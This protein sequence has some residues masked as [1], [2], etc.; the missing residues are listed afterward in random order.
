[1]YLLRRSL[2]FSLLLLLLNPLTASLAHAR[3]ATDDA[4]V[5]N[6]AKLL[7]YVL[8]QQ[9]TQHH[10]S[11]KAIDDKFS[12]AT[13]DLYLKQLDFQKRFLLA[14]DVAQLRAYADRIDDEF[15]LGQIEL[16]A[17]A[18][19]LL[20]KRI[21]Q[22]RKIVAELLTR[23]FDFSREEELE[24][25]PEKLAWVADSAALKERWRKILKYQVM[26]RMLT[27]E[28]NPESDKKGAG[29]GKK[30]PSA[31]P[32]TQA[33][34]RKKIAKRFDHFFDRLL[35]DTLRDHYDR[36]FNAATR[37]FDPHTS[38]F[39]PK[40]KED[41][42]IGM[43]GSLEGIGATLR[44][45]DGFIKVVRVIPGS[46]AAR[47]GELAAEDTILAVAQGDEEPVDVTDTRLRDAVELIRGP[48]G[49]EVR[50]TVKKADG[51]T[52]VIPIV[53]DV[54]EIEETFVKWT[55]IPDP[56]T[57]KLFGYIRIPSFYRDFKGPFQGGT[58]RNVTDDVEKAL[59]DLKKS[60]ID[61]L[62]IDL[63]NNGGGALT[64]AVKI[65]GLFIKS[66][67][68]VQVKSSNGQ[69]RVLDDRDPDVAYDG[70]MLVL[71]NRFSAS[72]SEIFA[73]ALQDYHRALIVGSEHTYGKGTVQTILD[74]DRAIPFRNM[75]KYKP[76][77]ALKITT[78]KFYRV[79]GGSTQDKGVEADLILPDRMQYVKS[80][81]KYM[82]YALPW[83][84]VPAAR[85][86]P[87]PR[88][89]QSLKVLIENSRKRLEKNKEFQEIVSDAEKVKER[90]NKTRLTLNIA[91]AR[92]ERAEM[93]DSNDDPNAFHDGLAMDKDTD[94]PLDEAAKHK[95]WE[96]QVR[97]DPYTREGVAILD[98]LLA[99]T[100]SVGKTGAETTTANTD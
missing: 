89:K 61:G 3:P 27:L 18:G 9:L 62:L 29:K 1:M 67:P 90:R 17:I 23:K 40:Q 39:A 51:K 12:E 98:D 92:K 34:A 95:R 97:K 36:F 37:A 43:R 20:D 54:V 94:K 26:V 45:E 46:A 48:K 75:E 38:Y 100:L 83:D 58:G 88:P 69:V 68:V 65:S 99:G 70:P 50:L 7:S 86:T 56:K 77:G 84:T 2:V 15:K 64:D 72:A 81:E 14:S 21:R 53:R 31:K 42:E 87:W 79:S 10:F 41:F 55:T 96:E 28:E 66:G 76:L 93:D 32:E 80:G 25:D 60:R 16:P 22:V 47:Q 85:Y 49:T 24:S 59:Q 4:D 30:D 63:R 57:G 82:D 78:Q 91:K 73:A 6:R 11:H 8:R 13:F 74:L 44:E 35:K 5:A 71:V 33:E 52:R 19:Q